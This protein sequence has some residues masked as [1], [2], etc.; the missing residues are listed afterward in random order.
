[1]WSTSMPVI[2]AANDFG[3]HLNNSEFLRRY[4]RRLLRNARASEPSKALP[5]LR[6]ISAMKVTQELRMTDIYAVRASLQLKHVLH[7]LGREMGFASC[8]A[9]KN[10]IDVCS[11]SALDRYRLEL[12]MFG[13]FQQNWFANADI[14]QDWQKQHGGYLIAYDRQVVAILA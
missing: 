4:A 13:D 2:A 5:V 14:A 9:C 1:M 12:W 11:G 7:M 10:R 3:N 8:E 6:R